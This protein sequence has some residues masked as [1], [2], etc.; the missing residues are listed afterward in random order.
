MQL[1]QTS[2]SGGEKCLTNQTQ[3]DFTKQ[4]SS[5]INLENR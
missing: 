1:K 3:Q 2:I 5:K 4:H